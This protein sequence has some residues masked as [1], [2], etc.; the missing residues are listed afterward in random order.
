MNKIEKI[1][2]YSSK[3][4]NSPKKKKKYKNKNNNKDAKLNYQKLFLNKIE[5]N[6]EELN[7]EEIDELKISR[8]H[9]QKK[10][11]LH[12]SYSSSIIDNPYKNKIGNSQCN[13]G[14]LNSKANGSKYISN[15]I[16]TVCL[17]DPRK[18]MNT[19]LLIILLL[20]IFEKIK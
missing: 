17:I 8:F 16:K 2:I 19:I 6:K 14:Y 11:I 3:T 13:N 18:N 9:T 15:D 7:S 4:K 20:F 5:K 1:P 10:I 12:G